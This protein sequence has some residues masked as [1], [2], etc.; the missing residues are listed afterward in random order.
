MQLS[1]KQQKR[2]TQ[3]PTRTAAAALTL[4][5]LPLS[6]AAQFFSEPSASADWSTQQTALTLSQSSGETLCQT[7]WNAHWAPAGIDLAI[8]ETLGPSQGGCPLVTLSRSADISTIVAPAA[9]ASANLEFRIGALA[10][11]EVA[12]LGTAT[13]TMTGSGDAAFVVDQWCTVDALVNFV[14]DAGIDAAT[15]TLSAAFRGP[16]DPL[17]GVPVLLNESWDGSTR[18][19]QAFESLL[20]APG[21][22]ELHAELSGQFLPIR[23]L[24]YAARSKALVQLDQPN[25]APPP[26]LWDLDA[27]G[28][29]DLADA[30]LWAD[31]PTDTDGDGDAD[32]LDLQL[33]LALARA[34]GSFAT[35][36]DN[37]GIPDQCAPACPADFNLDQT[38]DFF[39]ILAYLEAFATSDPR[40][41]LNQ[42]QVL[43]FFD[44]LAFLDAFSRGC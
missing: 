38:V 40:A 43:D 41:D 17:T 18:H 20:L 33:L 24:S 19:L 14:A 37:D 32:N 36:N 29:V 16:I 1:A 42:D 15:N 28:V 5:A 26:P 7:P 6:A 8:S 31:D 11:F 12:R 25:P 44:L 39:D 3:H 10:S 35:D 9:S 30:C 21:R 4:A 23:V 13:G 34:A 27:N 22:Y 2:R